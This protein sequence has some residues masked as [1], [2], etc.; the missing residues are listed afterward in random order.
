MARDALLAQHDIVL[1][2]VPVLVDQMLHQRRER[3]L[4]PERP[5][6]HLRHGPLADVLHA[7]AVGDQVLLDLGHLAHVELELVL[8]RQHT[9]LVIDTTTTRRHD[10]DTK[11]TKG[12]GHT[13]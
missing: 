4:R 7:L 2:M 13:W 5:G 11:M 12:V 8:C 10:D 6:V 3:S 9:G 1:V